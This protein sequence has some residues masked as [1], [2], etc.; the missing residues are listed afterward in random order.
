MRIVH[1]RLL[2]MIP[3]LSIFL[4]VEEPDLDLA[5][6]EQYVKRS[7]QIL[8]FASKGCAVCWISIP[9]PYLGQPSPLAPYS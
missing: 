9:R 2:E 8:I 4:D 6:L 1:T 3:F 5:K 7:K